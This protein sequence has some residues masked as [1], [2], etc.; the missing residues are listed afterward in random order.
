MNSKIHFPKKTT[1]VA[2]LFMLVFCIVTTTFSSYVEKQPTRARTD[3]QATGAI[4]VNN[5]AIIYFDNSNT[6]WSDSCIQFVIGH[7]S[8]SSTY[9]MTK[10]AN[11]KMYY[12][13]MPSWSGATYTAFMG[14]PSKWDDGNW[15]PGNITNAN[16]Y[17]GTYTG[18]WTFESNVRYIFSTTGSSNGTSTSPTYLS[19][20]TALNSTQTVTVQ[21]SDDD[22]SS[23][24]DSSAPAKVTISGYKMSADTTA[25]STTAST[26]KGSTS[27]AN[28]SAAR[29]STVKLSYSSMATDYKF[30]GWYNSSGTRVGTGTSY[31]YTCTSS[32]ETYY[33]RF[34]YSKTFSTGNLIYFDTRNNSGWLSDTA[35]MYVQFDDSTTGSTSNRAEMTKIS[36][37]LYKYKFTADTA[38][39]VSKIRFWR[40][41]STEMWNFTNTLSATEFSNNKNCIYLMG[42]TSWDGSGGKDKLTISTF[43]TPKLTVSPTEINLGETVK[44]TSETALLKYTIGTTSYTTTPI[45]TQYIF[46][47]GATTGTVNN[48]IVSVN[49]NEYNWTPDEAGTYY[50]KVQISSAVASTSSTA[51]TSTSTYKKL[52]VNAV[53]KTELTLTQN[54]AG[55]VKIGNSSYTST[56]E[57]V[58]IDQNTYNMTVTP[59]TDYYISSITVNGTALADILGKTTYT[60][61]ITFDTE[62][63]TIAV[64]YAKKPVITVVQNNGTGTVTPKNGAVVEYNSNVNVSVTPPSGKYIKSISGSVTSGACVSYQGT[65]TGVKAN[66]TITITYADNPKVTFTHTGA[67]GSVSPSSGKAVAYGSDKTFTITPPSG[68]YISAVTKTSGT[69][70]LPEYTATA[71]K[72]T[73]NITQIESDVVVDIKY[74]ANPKITVVDSTKTNNDAVVTPGKVVSVTYG[75]SRALTITAANV[76][77]HYVKV[78]AFDSADSSADYATLTTDDVKSGTREFTVS[79]VTRDVTV[80][81]T[82][83]EQPKVKFTEDGGSGTFKNSSNN[84]F[85]AADGTTVL[86]GG[87]ETVTITPPSGYYI[88]AIVNQS[89]SNCSIETYSPENSEPYELRV[90]DV[91][92]DS[93]IKVTYKKNPIVKINKQVGGTGTIT[94]DIEQS[95][96]YKTSA[97]F[98][99]TPPSGKYIK[100]FTKTSGSGVLPEY[101]PQSGTYT[102]TVTDVTSNTYITVTYAD[103]PKINFTESGASG[104]I[105]TV[106]GNQISSGEGFEYGTVVNVKVTPPTGYYIKTV[107]LNGDDV[108]GG[109]ASYTDSITITTDLNY[110]ITYSQS[111]RVT[112]NTTGAGDDRGTITGDGPVVY[113][114][115]TTVHIVPPTGYYVS[116]VSITYANPA[117]TENDTVN[118]P[119][120][121][122]DRTFAN[123]T[124][125]MTLDVTYSSNPIATLRVMGTTMARRGTATSLAYGLM[126]ILPSNSMSVNYGGDLSLSMFIPAGHSAVVSINSSEYKTYAVSKSSDNQQQLLTIKA[127][128]TNIKDNTIMIVVTY[129]KKTLSGSSGYWGTKLLHLDNKCD[130]TGYAR[131]VAGFA[132]DSSGTDAIYFSFRPTS[133]V[134]AD[135]KGEY[136]VPIPDGYNYTKIFRL[137]KLN[138]TTNDPNDSSNVCWNYTQTYRTIATYNKFTF[139]NYNTTDTK[140]MTGSWSKVTD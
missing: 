42:D 25:S 78:I 87:S 23:Y 140:V 125:D 109:G 61:S 138:T 86:Y 68:Y 76:N 15:G 83:S 9:T 29:T 18:S 67:K 40:G 120:D 74:T 65:I 117:S 11:T 73:L 37:C 107:T 119:A 90:S 36:E 47:Q 53:V 112:V 14:T 45:D 75:G 134:T 6:N 63:A 24:A 26:T 48:N 5:G 136:I 80:L 50:L 77:T 52:V 97:T 56:S 38:Q 121:I 116:A 94:P 108:D 54:V 41:N 51:K 123:V 110:V 21:S 93:T 33:A 28:I 49:E 139:K 131:F 133:S 92:D 57:T 126:N 113:G 118:A 34:E 132:K 8:Y 96:V 32:A 27:S 84:T 88:S 129:Y 105:F 55:T 114:G 122:Y 124:C 103:N 10:I 70:T 16:H 100:S 111:P 12:V 85:A 95:V 137:D 81:Y 64:K 39:D 98:T 22:G 43:D 66:R 102:L 17:T 71:G 79:N 89:K 101:T 20:N 1:I 19:A 13:K 91:T 104:G 135:S 127:G 4:A 30:V 62:T 7:S 130:A 128:G 115:S 60:G 44:L 106:N 69:A 35:K 3:L 58:E 72:L 82:Y 2:L 99:V 31:S 59:P 46:K